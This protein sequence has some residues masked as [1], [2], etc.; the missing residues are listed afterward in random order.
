MIRV[1]E[2]GIAFVMVQLFSRIPIGRLVSH[3]LSFPHGSGAAILETSVDGLVFTAAHEKAKLEVFLV[4]FIVRVIGLHGRDDL[5]IGE[6]K[7]LGNDTL[8]DGITAGQT[9]HFDHQYTVPESLFYVG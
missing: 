1:G 9:F 5:G 8:V 2:Q 4:E 6:L 3:V 7:G